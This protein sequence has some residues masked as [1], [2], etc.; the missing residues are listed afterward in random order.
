MTTTPSSGESAAN[1]GGG[2]PSQG[3]VTVGDTKTTPDVGSSAAKM[4]DCDS[5]AQKGVFQP[6]Q[7]VLVIDQ[8]DIWLQWIGALE[9]AL[10][11]TLGNYIQK[12]KKGNKMSVNKNE[13]KAD[14]AAR[15]TTCTSDQDFRP[16]K[17]FLV[18]DDQDSNLQSFQFKNVLAIYDPRMS[19]WNAFDYMHHQFS[20]GEESVL[21][22]MLCGINSVLSEI[23]ELEC[24]FNKWAQRDAESLG[25]PYWN[26]EK[27]FTTQTLGTGEYFIHDTEADGRTL[28]YPCQQER[29][30]ALMSAV[31][32]TLVQLDSAPTTTPET[33]VEDCQ[34]KSEMQYKS[35]DE[36]HFNTVVILAN[37]LYKNVLEKLSSHRVIVIVERDLKFSSIPEVVRQNCND[38]TRNALWL[39]PTGIYSHVKFNQNSGC[40]SYG[41][42]VPLTRVSYDGTL[43]TREEC[44]VRTSDFLSHSKDLQESV[45]KELGP[46][47]VVLFLPLLPAVIVQDDKWPNHKSL[48]E[49][50]G[51]I[52][53][54]IAT[55][56]SLSILDI[57]YNDLC[58][59]WSSVVIE[60]AF[61][62][63]SA[64]M[65]DYIN[66]KQNKNLLKVTDCKMYS[67]AFKDWRNMCKEIFK[68]ALF[69][70]PKEFSSSSNSQ[71]V[72]NATSPLNNLPFNMVKTPDQGNVQVL[73]LPDEA[74][75]YTTHPISGTSK[76]EISAS[77]SSSQSKHQ[78]ETLPLFQQIV[79]FC[80]KYIPVNLIELSKHLPVHFVYENITFDEVGQATLLR[81]QKKWSYHTLWFVISDVLQVATSVEVVPKCDMV[82]CPNPLKGFNLNC[83]QI[84][85]YGPVNSNIKIIV[86]NVISKVEKFA[87]SVTEELEEGSAIFFAP[88]SPATMFWGDSSSTVTHDYLHKVGDA[89]LNFPIVSGR[90]KDWED[91]SDHLRHEWTT[92]VINNMQN[93]TEPLQ[94]LTTYLECK[95]KILFFNHVET[96]TYDNTIFDQG[97]WNRVV[98]G[99]LLYFTTRGFKE[100]DDETSLCKVASCQ[101]VADATSGDLS[102]L[103]ANTDGQQ[104]KTLKEVQTIPMQVEQSSNEYIKGSSSRS[105]K[106]SDVQ[107]SVLVDVRQSEDPPAEC[108]PMVSD[109]RQVEPT[110]EHTAKST[111]QLLKGSSAKLSKETP[112]KLS[113]ETPTKLSKETPAKLSKDTSAKL[114]KDALV[115]LSKETP[116][117]LSKETPVKLS[118]E[119]PVKLSKETPVT[120]LK[121]T[122]DKLP[123][124]TSAK[125][126]EETPDK[127]SKDTLAKLS[128]HTPAKLPKDTCAKLSEETPD[129]LPKDTSAKLSK[130]AST[131]LSKDTSAKLSKDTSAKLSEETSA[132]LSKDTSA[133]LSKDTSAKLSKDTSAKLSE[134][135]P[136]KLSK[137]TSAKLSKDT[138]AKLSKETSAKLSEEAPDKLSKDTSTKLSK[139]TSAKLSE[140]APDKLSKDTSTKLS[141]DTS[142]KLSK[143]TL[144][145]LHKLPK[146]TS[147]KLS[148]ETSAKLSEETPDKLSKDTLAKRSKDTSAKL[149]KDTSAKLSKDASTKLSKDTSAK[150]SK[151]ASTKLS[152]DTFAK[153]SEETPDKLPKDTSAKLSKDTSAKLSKDASTKLSKDTSA[154]LSKDASTKL[155]KDTSAKLSKDT[156][157]KLSKETFAKLSEETSARLSKDTSAKLS[158]DTSAKLS[159][160]TSAKLPKDTSAKLSKDTLAKLSK[161]TSAKLSKDTSAKLSKDTLAKLSKDTCAKMSKDTCAKLSKDTSAKLSKDTTAKLS[162]ETP[163]KMSKDTSAK[164]SKDTSANLSKDTTTKLSEETPDKM[165]KDTS[166]MLSKNTSAKLSEETPDK[167]S[168]DTSAKLS[169]D[170]S[171]KLSKD[172]SAKLSKDTSAKLSKDT[173]AKLSKDTSTK[174]SKNTSVKLSIETS[175]KLSKDTSANLSKDTTA[176]VSK[177]TSAKLSKETPAKLSKDTSDKFSSVTSAELLTEPA[178]L[179]IKLAQD[180]TQSS[181]QPAESP[182]K[183]PVEPSKHHEELAKQLA[184]PTKLSVEPV[185]RSVEPVKE[186]VEPTVAPDKPITEPT[187]PPVEYT[188]PTAEPAKPTADPAMA[189]A[190]RAKPSIMPPKPLVEPVEESIKLTQKIAVPSTR[191]LA[192]LTKQ[193]AEL[194]KQPAELN[195]QPAELTKQPAELT[196][197]PA[198]LTKQLAK[199]TKQPAELTKQPAELTKQP[200]EL[201]KQPA[202]LTKQPA[203]LTKQPAELAKHPAELAKQPAELPKQPAEL[204]KQSAELAK[205]PAELIKQP[206][207]LTKQPA[208]ACIMGPIASIKQV[209]VLSSQQSTEP[210]ARVG[211]MYVNSHIKTLD[212]CESS[213]TTEKQI[214][215]VSNSNSATVDHESSPPSKTQW[216]TDRGRVD[217]IN[218]MIETN[219]RQV[220]KVE[221]L[222]TKTG[223]VKM[224]ESLKTKTGEMKKVAS[225]KT[226]VVK[227]FESENIAHGHDSGS[228]KKGGI[229]E[230]TRVQLKNDYKLASTSKYLVHEVHS[231]DEE[232]CYQRSKLLTASTSTK[233]KSH[234]KSSQ[235]YRAR[236]YL[237]VRASN[238]SEITPISVIQ[239]VFQACGAPYPGKYDGDELVFTFRT[240]KFSSLCVAELNNLRLLDRHLKV[241]LEYASHD[242]ESNYNY[243]DELALDNEVEETLREEEEKMVDYVKK[244]ID[245]GINVFGFKVKICIKDVCSCPDLCLDYHTLADRRRSPGFFEYC[246]EM[247]QVVTRGEN[248]IQG[249]SCPYAHTLLEREY[250]IKRFRSL[251]CTGWIVNRCCPKKEEVCPYVHPESPDCMYHKSWHDLYVE[252]LGNTLTFLVEAVRNTFKL[253]IAPGI[254]VL[255]ITPSLLVARLLKLAL[256]DLAQI[257]LQTVVS[258][259]HE[260]Q[261]L[262]KG[263]VVIGTPGALSKILVTKEASSYLCNTRAVIVDDITNILKDFMHQHQLSYILSKVLNNKGLNRVVVTEKF[264]DYEMSIAADLMKTKFVK[265]SMEN[266]NIKSFRRVNEKYEAADCEE[267][268]K[269]HSWSPEQTH[270]KRSHH[271]SYKKHKRRNLSPL[272]HRFQKE[273]HSLS[274][275]KKLQKRRSLSPFSEELQKRRSLSPSS[276]EL[277]KRRSLSPSSEELQKRRSLSP[278]SEE[279]QKR[280][281]LSPTFGRLQKKRSLSPSSEKKLQK[282]RSLS[283]S[284]GRLQK[285]RILSPSSEKKLQK[286]R[287]LSPSSGRLQKKRSLSPSSEKKLQK[288]RHV[289]SSSKKK[290]QKRSALPNSEKLQKK[291]SLSPSSE[292]KLQKKRSSLPS[293]V[294]LQK[295]KSHSSK[296][297][298]SCSPLSPSLEESHKQRR[299]SLTESSN[300]SVV[301]LASGTPSPTSSNY[302]NF[303]DETRTLFLAAKEDLRNDHQL[304]YQTYSEVPEVHP[305]YEE[306]YE[307]FKREYGVMYG[308]NESPQEC[309]K[310]WLIFWNEFMTSELREKWIKKREKLVQQFETVTA[311]KKSSTEKLKENLK[312][313]MEKC[314]YI[315][316]PRPSSAESPE[317]LGQIPSIGNLSTDSVHGCSLDLTE[318]YPTNRLDASNQWEGD[319]ILQP[320]KVLPV[321]CTSQQKDYLTCMPS[322]EKSQVLEFSLPHTLALLAELCEPLGLLGPALRI[323]IHRVKNSGTD[324]E[325]LSQ[326]FAD[327]YN[328]SLIKMASEKLEILSES[329]EGSSKEKLLQGSTQAVELLKYISSCCLAVKKPF[330]GVDVDKVARA[331]MGEDAANIVLFIKN[332]LGYKG[333][334]NPT[335]EDINEIFLAVSS[336]HFSMALEK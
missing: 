219:A 221:S 196:K 336:K 69:D 188:K 187:K 225:L 255:V 192:E 95:S 251:V 77:S 119:T 306:K 2:Y 260:H 111:D 125:L 98:K 102:A 317:C 180:P 326:I 291:T 112:T 113:K 164:L 243:Q 189:V 324:T 266:L 299:R 147:D 321:A 151:D 173:S 11:N 156:S 20:T 307:I 74:V 129:K 117:K 73:N 264:S 209:T 245:T 59:A 139:D 310:L 334:L 143:D 279:L 311:K 261:S 154:K 216:K 4:T 142:A 132:K 101:I 322:N 63:L 110:K 53:P 23:T 312:Y 40:G 271:I 16:Q 105:L 155:S 294:K 60:P 195:K 160:N 296:R 207:E 82:N 190:E 36:R 100:Q 335:V 181:N 97:A 50:V 12:V 5:V 329:A 246:D 166:A 304:E 204:A 224:V 199:L 263:T 186:A 300:S 89:G 286:K 37:N 29:K 27:I 28:T 208:E 134:E 284:S 259:T 90:Q 184:E 254:R 242:G 200:A 277:Q 96:K 233:G 124:E 239:K 62:D 21:F 146:D 148:K 217:G 183:E 31:R 131:K 18:V 92:W 287:S 175:S 79:V 249:D 76:Q 126:S 282:K 211:M 67:D 235:H 57:V 174:L 212:A 295:Q 301:N 44:K 75:S 13:K 283:P 333:V 214:N 64:V 218:I 320:K 241:K 176:K 276:E 24:Q 115:K 314:N 228:S 215:I 330:N 86:D 106:D 159:K 108:P 32:K 133:K 185:R 149:S 316:S 305:E 281:S 8:Q 83:G 191:E 168:K 253:P 223:Q 163:D 41:C 91:C 26:I 230:I 227:K 161:D 315:A 68:L 288:K 289:L 265:A 332:T 87:Y 81:Y 109:K 72:S 35:S 153:L 309:K 236:K 56:F 158:K 272:S 256:H 205:Q 52:C 55:Q 14:T 61:N 232:T 285:K 34:E 136:D 51:T 323:I 1:V 280:R 198:E 234:K 179:H 244:W 293:S 80:K 273:R 257:F 328:I 15:G 84:Y 165:S 45:K 49:A 167:M 290:F 313:Q 229:I 104:N 78:T 222:K 10:K 325:R 197:Q 157:A 203:E 331:T 250:H 135:T 99:L 66:T 252:G 269:H 240:L 137:D 6:K 278:F 172:T 43:P 145:K 88:L 38:R 42:H 141:K 237:L 210:S 130:D 107:Q 116:V 39:L 308:E 231:D 194:T 226:N 144:A 177:D 65:F 270:R 303:D 319:S 58:N 22:I 302:P 213:F 70:T 33:P 150:L 220:E 71:S 30:V 268:H 193:P 152:K 9:L 46:K 297:K 19:Y 169:K 275:E 25:F 103:T 118:K 140:E 128:K 7:I 318:N 238:I 258:V 121:E 127:L 182:V 48:H 178:K 85:Q 292:K 327:D 54:F 262:E 247:C 248:C 47:S 206:A 3:A 298:R 138:S 120:L 93:Y 17:V 114:S 201:T 123:K 170:T 274:S 94:L 171:A 162:E 202:E 122:P 267:I